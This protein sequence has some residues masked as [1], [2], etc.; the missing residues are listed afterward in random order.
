MH[1][2]P[3]QTVLWIPDILEVWLQITNQPNFHRKPPH[4]NALSFVGPA[5]N[6]FPLIHIWRFSSSG[7]GLSI[8]LNARPVTSA[9]ELVPLSP[10]AFWGARCGSDGGRRGERGRATEC[11][12]LK[13]ICQLAPRLL[14]PKLLRF[15]TSSGKSERPASRTK[16]LGGL[17]C[18]PSPQ[19][20]YSRP[21][22][23]KTIARTSIYNS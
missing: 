12:V 18:S 9:P 7:P 1:C 17:S 19:I 21:T 8:T 20:I 5:P 14:S 10:S 13:E 23:G 4:N 22:N 11:K 16:A 2:G 3:C 15:K 6:A